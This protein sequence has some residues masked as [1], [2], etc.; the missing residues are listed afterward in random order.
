VARIPHNKKWATRKEAKAYKDRRYYLNNYAKIKNKTLLKTYGIT[1]EQYELLLKKQNNRCAICDKP[2]EESRH[3]K[4]YVDHCHTTKV[5][6]G[7]LCDQCNFAIGLL[8]D[9]PVLFMKTANYL[10]SGEIK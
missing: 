4:L 1:L 2:G 7:L 9:S 8:K 5:V 3:G 6:R 10:L